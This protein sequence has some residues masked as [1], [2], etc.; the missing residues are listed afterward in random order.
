MQSVAWQTKK[1]MR[2]DSVVINP[3]ALSI[4]LIAANVEISETKTS[5]TLSNPA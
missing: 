3:L 4:V 2:L 1:K 5:H